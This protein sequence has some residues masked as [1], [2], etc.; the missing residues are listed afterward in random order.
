MLR[1]QFRF[2]RMPWWVVFVAG[3]FLVLKVFAL[4]DSPCAVLG[5]PSPV[6]KRSLKKAYRSL[7]MC[8]HPDRMSTRSAYDKERAETLFK[9]VTAAEEELADYLKSGGRQAGCRENP[10][11]VKVREHFKKESVFLKKCNRPQSQVFSDGSDTALLKELWCAC[12]VAPASEEGG[13]G[14]SGGLRPAGPGL[15]VGCKRI[16]FCCT[17]P[18][19]WTGHAAPAHASRSNTQRAVWRRFRA[20]ATC[21]RCRRW[22]SCTSSRTCCR[23]Q[24]ARTC[25]RSGRCSSNT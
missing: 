10:N 22:S 21:W 5:V 19:P 23:R 16:E 3:M 1:D 14:E 9:R 13:G 4:Y 2:R 8:T 18:P 12:G 17:L 11:C 25:G 15:T 7:S 24:P 20:T 6:N